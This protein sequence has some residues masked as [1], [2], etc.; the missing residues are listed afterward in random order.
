MNMT[1]PT[2]NTASILKEKDKKLKQIVQGYKLVNL[3]YNLTEI[4]MIAGISVRNAQYKCELSWKFRISPRNFGMTNPIFTAFWS[5]EVSIYE[6]G[7]EVHDAVYSKRD[8]D[9]KILEQDIYSNTGFRII[10]EKE[11]KNGKP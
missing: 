2:T 9:E 4:A 7:I 10:I 6:A 11:K 3:G 8:I 1:I 5:G